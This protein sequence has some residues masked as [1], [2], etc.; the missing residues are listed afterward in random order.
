MA[1]AKEI[2]IKHDLPIHDIPSLYRRAK[3][4]YGQ[5]AVK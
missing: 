2:A 5:Q 4:L 1:K 3:K